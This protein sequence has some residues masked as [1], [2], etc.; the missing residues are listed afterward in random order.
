MTYVKVRLSFSG[1]TSSLTAPGMCA[2]WNSIS[3][4][5]PFGRKVTVSKIQKFCT[6]SISVRTALGSVNHGVNGS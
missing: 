1:V 2:R 4:S 3:L 6:V 5:A